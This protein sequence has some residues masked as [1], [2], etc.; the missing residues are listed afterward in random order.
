MYRPSGLTALSVFN[1]ILA[2]Y[3]LLGVLGLFIL[4]NQRASGAPAHGAANLPDALIYLALAYRTV[5]L[6]LLI[7]AGVG[8]LKLKRVLGRWIGTTEAL[9]SLVFFAVMVS[10]TRSQGVPFSFGYLSQ[11]VYPGLT[12]LLLNVVFRRNLVN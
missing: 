6:A 1:F 8:Y 4:L 2:G 7:T 12:L 3:N 11:L 5:D 9:V 10:Y